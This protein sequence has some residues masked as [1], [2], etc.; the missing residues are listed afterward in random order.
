MSLAMMFQYSFSEEKAAQM[1]GRS[2]NL[3]IEEGFCTKD[4]PI[5]DGK[6]IGTKQLTK[7]IIEKLQSLYDE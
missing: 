4:I 1:I 3:V 2:I 7:K 5:K 6:V